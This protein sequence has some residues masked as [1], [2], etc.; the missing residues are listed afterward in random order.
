MDLQLLTEL[1]SSLPSNVQLSTAGPPTPCSSDSRYQKE[2]SRTWAT[3]LTYTTAV[4][5]SQ[6]HSGLQ[7][8]WGA[9]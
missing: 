6:G 7:S 4:A 5:R 9:V 8:E 2:G 1:S 3:G